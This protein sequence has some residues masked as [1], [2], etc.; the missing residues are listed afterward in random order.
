[1]ASVWWEFGGW[2]VVMGGE[3]GEEEEVG[4]GERRGMR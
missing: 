4:R 2:M 3:R 1:M